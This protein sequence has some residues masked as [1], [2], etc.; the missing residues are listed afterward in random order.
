MT[1]RLPGAPSGPILRFPDVRA[2]C[3]RPARRVRGQALSPA[4]N[5]WLSR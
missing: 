5:G 4:L 1:M 3:G 2:A